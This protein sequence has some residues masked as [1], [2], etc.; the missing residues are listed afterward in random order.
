MLRE[1]EWLGS[2]AQGAVYKCRFRQEIVAVKRVKDR[3][4]AEIRHLRQ[5]HHPNIIQFKFVR[6][7]FPSFTLRR[8]GILSLDAISEGLVRI[9]PTFAW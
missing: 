8:R 7:L 1:L 4:E 6:L 9:R 5:L 2:G 3:K